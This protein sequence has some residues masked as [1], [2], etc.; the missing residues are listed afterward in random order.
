MGIGHLM[1]YMGLATSP[2][3]AVFGVVLVLVGWGAALVALA[4]ILLRAPH[5][6]KRHAYVTSGSR[7][8]AR[9]R[10]N[11]RRATGGHAS[12]A[13][14]ASFYEGIFQCDERHDI[15]GEI[16]SLWVTARA[17]SCCVVL[18]Y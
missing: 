1:F 5:P 7:V 2:T 16:V 17:V 14:T 3:L 8:T 10:S 12:T 4:N 18:A 15:N 9:G 13:A 6:D 11:T